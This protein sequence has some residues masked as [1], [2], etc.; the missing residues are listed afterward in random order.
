MDYLTQC[1]FHESFRRYDVIRPNLRD[2]LC[3]GSMGFWTFR[4]ARPLDYPDLRY[5][6]EGVHFQRLFN[7]G[8]AYLLTEDV[9]QDL[10]EALSIVYWFYSILKSNPG[11][12]KLV[13]WP[14]LLESLDEKLETPNLSKE[15]QQ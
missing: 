13:F 15:D 3:H 1:K 5:C 7:R 12:W 14:N 6:Q 8:G 9:L 11:Q 2:A 10:N 4:I